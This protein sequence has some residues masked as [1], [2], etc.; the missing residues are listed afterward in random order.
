MDDFTH[1]EGL[2][3]W[4]MNVLYRLS[5]EHLARVVHCA[6]EILGTRGLT[7]DPRL[8]LS[9]MRRTPPPAVTLAAKG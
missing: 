3:D 4:I 1:G 2:S 7:A 6:T 9:E 8:R 5:D